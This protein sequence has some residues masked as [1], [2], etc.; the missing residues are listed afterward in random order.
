MSPFLEED[1]FQ[2][3]THNCSIIIQN[4]CLPV[5]IGEVVLQLEAVVK[6]GLITGTQYRSI[7]II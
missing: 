1:K 5:A 7:N 3:E 6:V 2:E 4:I